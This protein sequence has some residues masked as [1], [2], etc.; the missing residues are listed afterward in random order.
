MVLCHI[1]A[2]LRQT[3]YGSRLLCPDGA[4]LWLFV[5][6]WGGS[7]SGVSDVQPSSANKIMR[8]DHSKRHPV[9]PFKIMARNA[10]MTLGKMYITWHV[11]DRNIKNSWNMWKQPVW[12][13]DLLFHPQAGYRHLICTNVTNFL[14]YCVLFC[15]IWRRCHILNVISGLWRRRS[16]TRLKWAK[17]VTRSQI[18]VTNY[19]IR[20]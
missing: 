1:K 14:Y 16:Q 3:K 4:V 17:Q 13:S 6:A 15:L 12:L 2:Y 7:V 18:D 19:Q 11:F 10:N 5:G 20:C 8:S 9:W